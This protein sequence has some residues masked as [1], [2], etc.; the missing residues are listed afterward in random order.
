MKQKNQLDLFVALAGDIPFRDEREAMTAPLVSLS[1]NKRTLIEWQGPS[2]QNV[3]VTA[4]EKYGVATIWDYD[5]ILWSISQINEAINAKLDTSPRIFFHPYDMLKATGRNTG[6]KGY[7]ELKAAM[8]RLQS[9]SISY[10]SISLKSKKRKLGAF[11]L[12]TAF[13][14]EETTDGKAKG[15]WIEL[16]QWLYQAVTNDRD[17]L[18][19]SPSYF[20]LKSGLDRFLYRLA[21]R[22]AGKQ[23]GW[24]F[25]FR[26][27]HSRSGS[28]QSFG[29]FSR[30][31]RK[32]ITRNVIPEYSLSEIKGANGP[33]LSLWRD[34][35][36]TEYL[37]DRRFNLKD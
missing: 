30:D 16:P 36:K 5:L 21:R 15:A 20:N 11:N 14:F 35:A 23:S 28:S 1:K 33:S 12:L 6:G 19:I 4:P 32:A 3:T 9:T 34:K 29:D 2:G 10:E 31:L 26:D 13:E 37:K 27:L 22:H 17:V 7:T 24:V 8:R 18:A 25:T